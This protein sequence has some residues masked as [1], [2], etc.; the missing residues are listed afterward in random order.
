MANLS[1]ER[2]IN[3]ASRIIDTSNSTV[4][5]IVRFDFICQPWPM[6]IFS[7]ERFSAGRSSGLSWR[8]EISEITDADLRMQRNQ[9]AYKYSVQA[10]PIFLSSKIPWSLPLL[11]FWILIKLSC[12]A[13]YFHTFVGRLFHRITCTV[14]HESFFHAMV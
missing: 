3:M 13:F 11:V 5:I 7:K 9:D 1:N 8:S 10:E 4:K 14:A 12:M 6:F 2:M